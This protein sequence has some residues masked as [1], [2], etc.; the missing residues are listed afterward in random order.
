MFFSRE[1]DSKTYSDSEVMLP[2]W[3]STCTAMRSRGDGLSLGK[4]S[5]RS[6][7]DIKSLLPRME[8]AKQNVTVECD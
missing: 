1:Q 8:Y 3:V 6:G 4:L 5:D 2:L 7:G